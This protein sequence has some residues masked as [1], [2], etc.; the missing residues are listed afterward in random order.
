MPAVRAPMW[1]LLVLVVALAAAL[2]AR[3]VFASSAAHPSGQAL[4]AWT[5]QLINEDRHAAGL[6]PLAANS[7]LEAVALGHSLD[8]AARDYF[9]HFTPEGASPYDRLHRAGIRYQV[10]GENIGMISGSN[11]HLMVQRI[12]AAM[13]RSPEHRANLL[14]RSFLRVGIGIALYDGELYLTEDFA[15]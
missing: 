7:H 15:G 12:E 4:V 1:R 9:S 3:S 6:A 5:L 8:M 14:R 2:G 11:R 10:A 13:L